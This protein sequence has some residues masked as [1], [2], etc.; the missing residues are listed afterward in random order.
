MARGAA[1]AVSHLVEGFGLAGDGHHGGHVVGQGAV[2][3]HVGAAL[4]LGGCVAQQ[5]QGQ[6]RLA[7]AGRAHH[8]HD[9]RGHPQ[10][11]HPGGQARGQPRAGRH[12]APGQGRDIGLHPEDV[13]EEVNR[14]G[15]RGG[16]LA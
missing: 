14:T 3:A 7:R 10:P 13:T 16:L 12:Q 15:F 9:A 11:R 4:A 5:A 2:E 8:P 6:L 1:H